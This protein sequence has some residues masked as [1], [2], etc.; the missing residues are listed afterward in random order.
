MKYLLAVLA[1]FFSISVSAKSLIFETAGN[2]MTLYDT[3]CV[4]EKVV[5]LIKPEA[6]KLYQEAHIFWQNNHYQAC[7]RVSPNSPEVVFI[8]DEDMDAGE[9]PMSVFKP[10]EMI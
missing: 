6:L 9:V 3:P 2:T 1:L 7:W 10:K 5:S 4:A 8:I